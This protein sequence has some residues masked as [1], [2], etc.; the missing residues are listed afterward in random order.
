MHSAMSPSGATTSIWKATAAPL[1][2]FPALQGASQA[3]V[4]I[5]GGG[6]TGLTL[7]TLL[8]AAGRDVVLLEA[9]ALGGGSSGNST[10]NLYETLSDG[11]HPVADKWGAEVARQV[12]ESRREAIAFIERH[13]AQLGVDCAFRR[14]PVLRYADDASSMQTLEQEYEAER[15]AGCAVRLSSDAPLPVG[16]GNALLLEGQAQ[17]HPLAYVL[18]LAR[19][20]AAE[21]CRIFER[22]P[23][24]AID[25]ERKLVQ[26]P[27]GSVSARELVLASHTPKGLYAVH[28]QMA[29]HREYGIA[30]RLDAGSYPPGIF[31]G[32]GSYP[33]SLRGLEYGGTSYLML[34]GE[35][36]KVGL[37]DSP[38]CLARLQ[39]FAR[40]HFGAAASEFRWSA[41]N[42]HSPDELPFVGRSS[43]SEAYFATGFATDG[44]TY[45]TLAATI[46]ADALLGRQNRWSELYRARRFSP[47]KSAKATLEEN[48]S[49]ASAFVKD[50]LNAQDADALA[51]LSPGGGMVVKGENGAVAV[52]RA[53]D[54]T[55]SAVSAKCTHMGCLVRWNEAEASWDC[56]CHGSRFDPAGGVIEG[57]A[58]RPLAP[59]S[60]P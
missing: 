43:A 37:H 54:G 3:D 49:V 59:R 8:G 21:G 34:V 6:I 44:L 27:L 31:W 13:A 25:E 5:V 51:E 58:L 10:G 20:A 47:V 56:P 30:W 16:K 55:L 41:Q 52:H 24:E 32:R 7:A 15:A 23:A 28:A 48:L 22:S 9:R 1:P 50:R 60:V 36:E 19:R 26:T 53:A 17:F 29:P 39:A 33:H 57:P 4:V 42:Y 2:P 14:C 46:L 11:L 38:A 35:E 12:V 45:G 40:E 18:G